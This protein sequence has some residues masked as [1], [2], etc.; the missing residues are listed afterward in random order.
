MRVRDG[1]S[2]SDGVRE[3]VGDIVPL[4]VTVTLVLCETEADV[5]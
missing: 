2:V 4:G 3:L 1:V 5:D